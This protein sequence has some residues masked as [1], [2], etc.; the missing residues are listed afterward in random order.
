MHLSYLTV[1]GDYGK[2]IF[3]KFNLEFLQLKLGKESCKEH[4][5][6]FATI[7]YKLLVNNPEIEGRLC[8]NREKNDNNFL[9]KEAYI[10]E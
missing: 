2:E 9:S 6:F 7:V 3:W 8:Q 1:V 10:K 5:L 4:L